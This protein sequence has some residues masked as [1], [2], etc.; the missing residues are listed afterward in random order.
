MKTLIPQSYGPNVTRLSEAY[1][2]SRYGENRYGSVGQ[3]MM[4]T[5]ERTGPIVSNPIPFRL[6]AGIA[7]NIL[8]ANPNR[9]GLIVQNLDPV[10][11]LNVSF[12]SVADA[13]SL[14]FPPGTIMLLDFI[15]PTDSVWLFAAVALSGFVNEMS[16]SV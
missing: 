6:T 7:L 10:A 3:A 8:Q 9:V 16:R 2:A 12:A 15:T 4:P 14:S 13:N 1:G 5:A 11:N